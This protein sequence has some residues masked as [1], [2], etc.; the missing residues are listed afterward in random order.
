MINYFNQ[1][2]EGIM[3]SR[4]TI[5]KERAQS[6]YNAILAAHP[7]L[8]EKI[9][10]KKS[11][12]LEIARN[13]ALKKSC[14]EAS[15][16]L[17][18]TDKEI[19]DYIKANNI[20][21]AVAYTCPLCKDTGYKDKKPCECL[22]Q[23][24]NA[25]IRKN[26][27]LTPLPGFTYKDN[28]FATNGAPQAEGMNKLYSKMQI[29]FNKFYST[30]YSNFLLCGAS[31]VGKTSLALAIANDLL[32]KNVSVLYLTSFELVNIFLDKHTHK[33]TALRQLYNYVLEC[34]MLIVDNLGAEPVYKN[35]T[36]EY[37]LS[38][39]EKRLGENKKTMLITQLN[40]PQLVGRY[41]ETLI[42]KFADKKYSISVGYIE[43]KDLRN[44]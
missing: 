30:R 15:S 37:L 27:S 12:E 34:E 3:N 39:L 2:L 4:R 41:G 38:T 20:K 18:E 42:K 10:I 16:R 23:E 29:V 5:A 33:D 21:F 28:T 43:G 19:S 11:L 44:L 17:K 26:L 35:V 1:T 24:Y 7:D 6:D 9:K 32:D 40:G 31:G 14:D 36:V 22:L 13:T 8:K 25:L